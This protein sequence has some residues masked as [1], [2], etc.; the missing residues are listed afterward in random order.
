MLLAKNKFLFMSMLF[1][2]VSIQAS[3]MSELATKF[4]GGAVIGF[5]AKRINATKIVGSAVLTR[6]VYK[7]F[8]NSHDEPYTLASMSD[9]LVAAGGFVAG[10]AFYDLAKKT[11]DKYYK[12]DGPKDEQLS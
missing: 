5:V 9:S 7:L 10:D 12:N 2:H 4:A 6:G 3:F 1:L 8:W 11:Y